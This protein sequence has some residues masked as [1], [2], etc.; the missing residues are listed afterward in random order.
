L[1]SHDPKSLKKSTAALDEATQP[2]AT[3]LIER[4]MEDAL[5]RK[6]VL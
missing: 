4:A 3:L 2:I 1:D 6:G 5:R